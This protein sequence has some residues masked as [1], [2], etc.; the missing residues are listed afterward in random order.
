MYIY[1]YVCVCV[2]IY[3][4]IETSFCA[5]FIPTHS[6]GMWLR[7]KRCTCGL[8]VLRPSFHR[9]AEP[10][11]RR[12]SRRQCSSVA[13]KRKKCKIVSSYY[14]DRHMTACSDEN[15]LIV[16]LK[17]KTANRESPVHAHIDMFELQQQEYLD[18]KRV[19]LYIA[20]MHAQSKELC[21]CILWIAAYIYMYIHIY[22]YICIYIY[23]YMH[24]C[25]YMHTCTHLDYRTFR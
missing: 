8:P 17:G 16:L 14:T 7:L 15:I 10:S 24:A 23:T 11:L 18:R 2:C 5:Q 13:G 25:T 6:I 20:L 22:V 1:I 4:Y 3:T 9:H 19:C 21:T 12:I